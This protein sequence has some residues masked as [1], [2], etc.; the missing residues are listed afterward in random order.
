MIKVLFFIHDLGQGGAEKVLV[1]LVNNMDLSQFD[2]SVIALF[3]GGVN[4]QFLSPDIKYHAIFPK[5]FPGNSHI[6]KIFPPELLHKWFIQDEYDIEISYLEGP[7]ARIISG[8]D[9]ANTK[10]VAWVHCTMRSPKDIRGA[11]RNTEEAKACYNA[12]DNMVFVSEGVRSAFLENCHYEGNTTVLYNTVESDQILK[13][14]Q[15]DAPEIDRDTIGIIAVGTLKPVKGF[16]RLLRVI[17]RLYAE[18]Y[19]IHLYLLGIGPQQK[20]LEQYISD[21]SLGDVVSL[22]GYKTNPYKYVAKC[23]LFVC[24]SFSEGFSTAV[25]ESL[26]VG[27]P[28][29]TVDVSGMREMLGNHNEFGLITQ[30]DEEAL[31]NGIKVLLDAPALLQHYKKQAMIRGNLFKTEQTV[32]DVEKMILKLVKEE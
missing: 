7:A 14:S 22:L 2:V 9:H 5:M 20:E 13:L 23:S 32:H 11:F 10:L 3:G 15:E 4:E 26:I 30:N 21:H 17:N 27:T 19:P 24:S 16:D 29:C 18:G 25:T 28:V 8:C 1:N 12:M 31:Y 6:M